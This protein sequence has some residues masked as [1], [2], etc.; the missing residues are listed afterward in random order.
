MSNITK[1]LSGDY[2]ADAIRKML[3]DDQNDADEYIN[4]N[5]ISYKVRDTAFLFVAAA[6]LSEGQNK[7]KNLLRKDAYYAFLK[8]DRSLFTTS[9]DMIDILTGKKSSSD[10]NV[11][12]KILKGGSYKIKNYYLENYNLKEI[13]GA[14]ILLTYTEEYLIPDMISEKYIPECIVYCGGGNIFA[15]VPDDCDES[16]A[17][18]LEKCA[19]DV[20]L[21]ADIAYYLSEPMKLEDIFGDNYRLKMALIENRLNERKKLI[22]N[23]FGCSEFS[24]G[25]ENIY[26]PPSSDDFDDSIKTEMKKEKGKTG[27]ICTSCGRRPGMYKGDRSN[28]SLCLSCLKKRTVGKSAKSEKYLRMYKKY[29]PDSKISLANGYSDIGS[30]AGRSGYFAVVYGDGNNMGGII[31]KFTRI[32]QMMEFSHDVKKIAAK[33]VFTS[34]SEH[35]ISEFE[36]VGLGGDDIFVIVN[37]EKAISFTLSMI[38]KYNSAFDKYR[39][40]GQVSTLSAGIAIAKNS[41]PVQIVLEAAEDCLSDAK[42]EV[43]KYTDNKGSLSFRILDNMDSSDENERT[44]L[45]Y[46]TQTAEKIVDYVKS[47]KSKGKQGKTA[48]RNILDAVLKSESDEEA[49]LFMEY[50]KVRNEKINLET[51]DLE[52]YTKNGLFYTKNDTGERFYIWNDLLDLLDFVE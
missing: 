38:K 13:R 11:M 23:T 4:T 12:M 7:D 18:E 45:P 3:S 5:N 29:N 10:C 48:L 20:L 32:N 42:S 8:N 35:N 22:I 1:I 15:V 30:I 14:S 27:V 16:F 28:E 21:S 26:I 17:M 33:S 34:M 52:G 6:Y 2:D 47:H 39:P 49:N 31:Q 36:V 51:P 40:L 37:G 41:T 9:W 25:T 46:L 44:M 24:D 43:K 50:F 19:K